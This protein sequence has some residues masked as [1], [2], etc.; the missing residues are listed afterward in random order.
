MER[1]SRENLHVVVFP[2]LAIGHL[3]PFFHL[4]KHLAQKGH[5]VY[6][7]STPKNLT[8]IP[9]IPPHLSSLLNLVSFPLPQIP[10]LP[11]DA[12][13][14]ADVPFR[15]QALLKRAFDS[16]EPALAAFLES[17]TPD[18]VILDYA[19]HWLYRRAAELGVSRAFLSLFNAAMLSFLGPPAG[20]IDGRDGGSS[21]EDFAAVPKWVPFETGVAYR[22]HEIAKNLDR[23]IDLN[24]DST[25]PDLVRFGLAADES[26]VVAVKSRPEFEPEWFGLLGELYRRPVFPVGF[27][28]PV[29]EDDGGGD[30]VEWVGIK[31]WLDEREEESVVYVALGTEA[32][33][34]RDELTELAL[35]LERSELPFF[36]VIRNSPGSDQPESDKLPDGFVERVKDRGMVH[37]GWAPQVRILSHDSVGG[38]LTHCGWNS[39]VEGLGLGRVLVLLPMVNDQGINARLLS[40]KGVG[41]EIPRNELDGSFGSD[42]VA[43]SIRLA[44]VDESGESLRVKVKNMRNLFGDKEGNDRYLNEFIS[45]L[46]ESRMSFLKDNRTRT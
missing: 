45:F 13:S 10:N 21:P 29:V 3:I 35:G 19:S 25:T 11:L 8:K 31:D 42:S 24:N 14:A 9:K 43:E 5:K 46:K 41:L 4:S 17:S 40:E 36:W 44:M 12:E 28:P 33:L 26:D 39:V 20:L 38:F 2:W 23:E 1:T 7:I 22:V 27:L 37:F 34:T 32:T 15:T 18:W 30:D 16:L 6:F